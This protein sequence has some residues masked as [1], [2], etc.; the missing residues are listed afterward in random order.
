M[1]KRPGGKFEV[2]VIKDELGNYTRFKV[3]KLAVFGAVAAVFLLIATLT[4]KVITLSNQH[5]KE[6]A[7]R[8]KLAQKLTELQNS[9]SKLSEENLKLKTQVAEL[10]RE[11][12]ETVKQLAKRVEI[13]NSLMRE[14]GIKT[15]SEGEGGAAVPIESVLLN[16]QI[17][18]KEVIPSIDT[19]IKDFK[20]TP[21][22]Y[23]TTGRITS[24]FGLRR[25]PL[26]GALEYHLGVDIANRWGTPIRATAEGKVVKAGWCGEL[27]RCV[28]IEHQNGFITRYG[29][30]GKILVKKGQKVKRGMIIGLMGSSGRSTGTHLHYAIKHKGKI[31]NPEPFLEVS[32]DKEEGKGGSGRD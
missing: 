3:P 29:H 14:I 2:I 12:E 20:T 23:P 9:L 11:R 19:L 10:Q 30:L 15:R 7:E 28:E 18:P 21:V 13:I 4:I 17:N 22:G 8:A 26:T 1:A 25:D 32:L 5:S 31:I 27:G 24:D 16:S 6:A